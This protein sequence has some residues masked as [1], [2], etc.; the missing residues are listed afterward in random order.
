MGYEL[1]V[2]VARS[3]DVYTLRSAA[4]RY[5]AIAVGSTVGADGGGETE[6]EALVVSML[7]IVVVDICGFV[8][9]TGNESK[10]RCFCD[11]SSA[12]PV[13][14]TTYIT[15]EEFGHFRSR[16]EVKDLPS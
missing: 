15:V 3:A 9:C 13:S 11:E 12:R 1:V 5:E 4:N 8:L 7:E 10:G 16:C 14:S 6:A 2:R